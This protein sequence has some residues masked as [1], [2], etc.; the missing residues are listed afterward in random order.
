MGRHGLIGEGG[1]VDLWRVFQLL[2]TFLTTN[3]FSIVIDC[4][5]FKPYSDM[6]EILQRLGVVRNRM[7][8]LKIRWRGFYVDLA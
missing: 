6:L 2:Q 7:R 3:S 4:L 5:S 1:A 8:P